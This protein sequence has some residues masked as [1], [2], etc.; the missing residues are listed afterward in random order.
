MDMRQNARQ[1]PLLRNNANIRRC[2]LT[3][4]ANISLTMAMAGTALAQPDDTMSLAEMASIRSIQ[5]NGADIFS[6]PFPGERWNGLTGEIS[7]SAVDMTLEGNGPLKFDVRRDFEAIPAQYPYDLATMSLRVPHLIIE[8]HNGFKTSGP[9][10][11][12]GSAITATNFTCAYWVTHH[13]LTFN[14]IKFVHETGTVKLIGR[15]FVDVSVKNNYPSSALY[16]SKDNWIL[17][18]L[19]NQYR[20]KSPAG[21][22]YLFDASQGAERYATV[23]DLQTGA[24][25]E[26]LEQWIPS[27]ERYWF[28]TYKINVASKHFRGNSLEFTYEDVNP[29]TDPNDSHY[30]TEKVYRARLPLFHESHIP[31][32][33][34][35]FNAGAIGEKRRLKRVKLKTAKENGVGT[36]DQTLEMIYNDLDDSCPGLLKKIES[37]PTSTRVAYVEYEYGQITYIPDHTGSGHSECVLHQVFKSHGSPT[38]RVRAWQFTYG[39]SDSQKYLSAIGGTGSRNNNW[40]THL[41]SY[42]IHPLRE[43]ISPTG[44]KVTYEYIPIYPGSPGITCSWQD[45]DQSTPI[46]DIEEGD[47][48]ACNGGANVAQVMHRKISGA[49]DDPTVADQVT[50]FTYMSPD[51]TNTYRVRRFVRE[52]GVEHLLEYGRID[53]A[54]KPLVMIPESARTTAHINRTLYAGRLAK[55]TIRDLNKPA[56]SEPIVKTFYTYAEN[57]KFARY[58]GDVIN[59][60]TRQWVEPPPSNVSWYSVN[61]GW[62]RQNNRLQY[63][64]DEQR[65]NPHRIITY[66]DTDSS[67]LGGL[68]YETRYDLYDEYNNP[69]E[70]VKHY[71]ELGQAIDF[72]DSTRRKKIWYRYDNDYTTKSLWLVGLLEEKEVDSGPDTKNLFDTYTYYPDGQMLSKTLAG[73]KT[74]YTY[75]P[76]G[77]VHTREDGRSNVATY[78]NYKMGVPQTVEDREEE[79]TTRVVDAFG[80]ITQEIDPEDIAINWEYADPFRRLTKTSRSSPAK[81]RIY[82]YAVWWN[83]SSAIYRKDREIVSGRY[84]KTTTYDSLGRVIQTEEENLTGGAS[85]KRTYEYDSL[86]RLEFVSDPYYSGVPSGIHYT[87]DSLGRV[88]SVKHSSDTQ[89]VLYCYGPPCNSEP[90]FNTSGTVR[91]GVAVRDQ[92]GYVT[93]YNTRSFGRPGVG[94]IVEVRQK[95]DP[96]DF[97][98]NDANY[99]DSTDVL[100]TSI[101]RNKIGFIEQVVQNIGNGGNANGNVSRTFSPYEYANTTT[102][103]VK[104]E[105]HTGFGVRTIDSYDQNGNITQ[106]TNFDGSQISYVYDKTDRLRYILNPAATGTIAAAP[107]IEKTYYKNGLLHQLI[108]GATTW[109][110]GYDANGLISSEVLSIDGQSFA[111]GYTHDDL[112]HLN[113]MTYPSGRVVDYDLN[114]FGETTLVDGYVSYAS[115]APAGQ[116]KEY[117]LDNGDFWT[118]TFDSRMRPDNISATSTFGGMLDFD[119]HYDARSNIT[120]ITDYFGPGSSLTNLQYDGLSRLERAD[121]PWGIAK[122]AYTST[123][124]IL[125]KHVGGENL[126]YTYGAT[127]RLLQSVSGA[128]PAYTNVIHDGNGNLTDTGFSE[129][130]YDHMNR[131]VSASTGA[132]DQD[133][134]YDGNGMRTKVTITPGGGNPSRTTYYVYTSAGDLVHE[135]DV[136]TGEQRDHIQFAGM[137]IATH[138]VHNRYDTD[139]DGMPDYFERLHG[140]DVRSAAN[141]SGDADNDGISNLREYL[142]GGL[143]TNTDSDWDGNP[144]APFN[145]SFPALDSSDSVKLEP[146]YRFLMQ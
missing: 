99:G 70:L 68:A 64:Y 69:K 94:D 106:V 129:Y 19:G 121:G 21:S 15:D 145:L 134:V 59:G 113:V 142:A 26:T 81:D 33:D 10:A 78:I 110:Y 22:V 131:L 127:S 67:N 116:L 135:Q 105:N 9:T 89:S 138:G 35:Y 52:T 34:T 90:L 32:G 91:D 109:T 143:P 82:Q 3:A 47:A 111:I 7:H 27:A 30:E 95:V 36:D 29:S 17:D 137:T 124:D 85:R 39:Y 51:P 125:K 38:S 71:N 83:P 117:M 16:I 49:S 58:R 62:R 13:N 133:S 1:K 84:Q 45:S 87:Y 141:A 56:G 100:V 92:A 96:A 60:D 122:Y 120:E 6:I 139:L 72:S 2:L 25:D 44:A 77:T 80:N 42:F 128:L 57:G 55:H 41:E 102:L 103:F 54:S 119:Y 114:A 23:R 18:C 97:S 88:K 104:E 20:V 130:Q 4:F 53:R 48:P 75:H 40:N 14:D 66:I 107:N 8:T 50:N 43:V 146:V 28:K 11:P 65:I 93:V 132:G 5:K 46:D 61:T 123:G 118:L 73:I 108:H 115:Y 79:T 24:Y 74:S 12:S 98:K 101:V 144:D 31:N 126:N 76:N 86:G 37:I 112:M 63:L 140:L 136:E